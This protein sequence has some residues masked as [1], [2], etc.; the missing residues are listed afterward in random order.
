MSEL[1]DTLPTTPSPQIPLTLQL[2]HFGSLS[3]PTHPQ[4]PLS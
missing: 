4:K 1:R 2:E 3:P